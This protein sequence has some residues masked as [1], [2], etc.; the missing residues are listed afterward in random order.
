MF[1][2]FPVVWGNL[3]RR[4]LRTILTLVCVAISFMLFGLLESFRYSVTTYADDYSNALIVQS[5]NIRLPFTHV[6][7]VREIQG[8]QSACGYLI[9]FVQLPPQKR[10]MV[11]AVSGDDLFV[12]HPAIRLDAAARDRWHSDRRAALIDEPLARENG[13]K[14]GDRIMLPGTKRVR[15]QRSDGVNALEV[16]IAGIYSTTTTTAL[17][18]HGI[19]TRFDYVSDVLGADR[20]R[21]EYIG[22]RFDSNIDV[23]VMR[24]RIDAAFETSAAPTKTYSARALLRAYYG[25]FREIARFAVIALVVSFATLLLIAGSVLLQAQRERLHELAVLQALGTSRESLLALL[26]AEAALMIVPAAMAGLLAAAAIAMQVPSNVEVPFGGTIPPHT[27]WLSALLALALI[28]SIAFVP[29]ARM[30]RMSL[31]LNLA[32]E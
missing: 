8:V 5:R 14:A 17:A 25:T 11:Q 30:R 6:A 19:F 16:V 4:K 24:A 3:A 28:A 31:A 20:A 2:W 1:K 22:A 13:W 23:D 12:V 21:L 9:T 26:F 18:A 15:F 10:L 27:L 32:R 7:R 29:C